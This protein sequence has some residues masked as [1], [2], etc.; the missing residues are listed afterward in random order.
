MF[1]EVLS[2]YG[3]RAMRVLIM[4]CIPLTVPPDLPS[5]SATPAFPE[6]N[7]ALP[8]QSVSSGRN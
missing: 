8:R 1:V 2:F 7:Y 4:G 6:C 3:L 5:V